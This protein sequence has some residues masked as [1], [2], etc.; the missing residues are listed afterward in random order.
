MYNKMLFILLVTSLS[1]AGQ[2]PNLTLS[3]N[4]VT[5]L[6]ENAAVGDAG[7]LNINGKQKRFTKR[8]LTERNVLINTEQ[9]FSYR[10]VCTK[11]KPKK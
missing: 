4:G 3:A 2:T 10:R 6:C 7:T 8:T 9:L 5:C 1:V 11:S